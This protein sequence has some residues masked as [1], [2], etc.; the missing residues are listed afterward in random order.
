MLGD[1]VR[2]HS[3]TVAPFTPF[4]LELI[5]T[6]PRITAD[7]LASIRIIMS[8]I[9]PMVKDLQDAFMAKTPNAVLGQVGC[10]PPDS[11]ILQNSPL[12]CV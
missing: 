4:D 2:K 10:L 5:A 1:L 12:F 7:D 6:S 11:A 8:D 9:S 3:I